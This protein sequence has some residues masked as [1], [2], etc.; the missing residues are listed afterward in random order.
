MKKS[1]PPRRLRS[2]LDPSLLRTWRLRMDIPLTE[3]MRCFGIHEKA[4]IVRWESG[5]CSPPK[6]IIQLYRRMFKLSEYLAANRGKPDW[7]L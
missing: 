3:L 4:I 7:S 5:I 2:D 6:E 1:L